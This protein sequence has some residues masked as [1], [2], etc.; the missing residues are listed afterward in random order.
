MRQVVSVCVSSRP[1][2][3]VWLSPSLSL[4]RSFRHASV[5]VPAITSGHP[6]GYTSTWRLWSARKTPIMSTGPQ[7]LVVSLR[8]PFSLSM[9]SCSATSFKKHHLP[10]RE[11][12]QIDERNLYL[13]RLV[14]P[15]L[16]LWCRAPNSCGW[17]L[18]MGKWDLCMCSIYRTWEDTITFIYKMLY[19]LFV[20]WTVLPRD[21]EKRGE[22]CIV[23]WSAWPMERSSCFWVWKETRF[24]R[25]PY[26]A[27]N[28]LSSLTAANR[29]WRWNWQEM[30][31]SGAVWESP[32][33]CSIW[34]L[35]NLFDD[36]TVRSRHQTILLGGVVHVV[37][38]SSS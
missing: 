18:R 3:V 13:L 30:V 17:G 31:T 28:R 32:W 27:L 37:V 1:L 4:P 2:M 8:G 19:C 20:L 25:I 35:L 12:L 26:W 6:W 29:A 38:M 15:L 5:C 21:W 14:E 23:C 33:R 22:W 16:S 24:S 9:E 36:S 10:N 7:A 34:R 11:C